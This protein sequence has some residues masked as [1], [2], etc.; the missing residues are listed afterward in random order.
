MGFTST[1][2]REKIWSLYQEGF[3][4]TRIAEKV[5]A[6]RVTV[7]RLISKIKRENGGCGDTRP[8]GISSS[9]ETNHVN[10]ESKWHDTTVS[11]RRRERS[12]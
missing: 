7:S 3:T 9:T 4:V 5:G 12:A 11:A 6:H 2:D 8:P 10:D 1:L